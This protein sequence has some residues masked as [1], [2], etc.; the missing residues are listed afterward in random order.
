MADYNLTGTYQLNK[1]LLDKLKDLM[2]VN[3]VTSANEKVF[4]AYAF[5]GGSINLTP[6]IQGA[7]IPDFT[8]LAGGPPFVVFGYTTGAGTNWEL[9]REQAAYVIWDSNTARLRRIQNYMKTLLERHDWT[10][11]EVNDF[12]S[13]S[14]FD[15]KYIQVTTA[16]SPDPA[17]S[18]QGRQKGLL[19]SAFEYTVDRDQRGMRL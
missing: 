4:K 6:F 15:F 16:T 2:W 14:P 9:T 7:Q 12:I 1:W 10:A 13:P 8:N 18:E 3:D 19:V 5:A 17:I 11:E